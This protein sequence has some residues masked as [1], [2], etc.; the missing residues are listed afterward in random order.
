[1]LIH[2]EEEEKLSEKLFNM[3]NVITYLKSLTEKEIE[4][5]GDKNTIK[6]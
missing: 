4:Q 3:I 2:E 1:M 5:L 6:K